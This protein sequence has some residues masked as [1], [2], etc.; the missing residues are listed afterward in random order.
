LPQLSAKLQGI[1]VTIEGLKHEPLIRRAIMKDA[2]CKKLNPSEK[3]GRRDGGGGGG[4]ADDDDGPS[5]CMDVDTIKAAMMRC[6]APGA[7]DVCP[8][9]LEAFQTSLLQLCGATTK[10]GCPPAFCSNP[11]IVPPTPTP[12]APTLGTEN[13]RHGSGR[14]RGDKLVAESLGVRPLGA[15]MRDGVGVG[16]TGALIVLIVVAL[17]LQVRRPRG[18]GL[19]ATNLTTAELV[20]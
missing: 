7:P 9:E 20:H 4:G 1:V 13:N 5:V 17:A 3:F 11:N 8:G 19:S 2:L 14:S 18:R 12:S 15:R 6:K 16:L 10:L